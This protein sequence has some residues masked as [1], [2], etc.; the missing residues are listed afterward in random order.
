MFSNGEG[1]PDLDL[2]FLCCPFLGLS[3]FFRD[4]PDLFGDFPGWL[5]AEK[6]NQ[7]FRGRKW[8]V[9]DPLFDPQNPPRISFLWVPFLRPFPGNEAHKLFSG[10]PKIRARKKPININILGGTVSGTNRN[11]PWDKWDP[12]RDKMGPVP[13]T[14]RPFSA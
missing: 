13:G 1:F 5:R 8:P 4:F 11:R 7:T 10:G 12:P 9:W 6:I 14:N 3:R 2:S